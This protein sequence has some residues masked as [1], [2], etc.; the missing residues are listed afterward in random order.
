MNTRRIVLLATA[1]LLIVVLVA[2]LTTRLNSS[3]TATSPPSN[4][5]A[6]TPTTLPPA[7]PGPTSSPGPSSSTGPADDHAEDPDVDNE[8]A[9]KPVVTNFGRQFTNTTGGNRPWRTRLVGDPNRPY[10][11]DAVAKQLATVDVD[12]VPAGHYD[13]YQVVKTST[14]E[15]AVKIDYHEGW[16]TILY[17]NTDGTT[18]QISAYDR[19]EQ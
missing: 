3:D 9:W 5:A 11:T 4:P 1:G 8:Q 2:F 10:V 6:A 19:Y 12:N 17:L 14:L 15:V 16:S 7:V 18:W 13:S